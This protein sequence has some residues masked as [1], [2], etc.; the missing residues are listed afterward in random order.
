MAPSV[1][2]LGIQHVD[3][4]ALYGNGKNEVLIGSVLQDPEYRKK[5]FIATKFGSVFDKD[6]K[7]HIS[8]K[9]VVVRQSC[10]AS[11]ARLQV[12]TID[13]YYQS[14][15][16]RT[17]NIEETWAEL[18]KL[19]KE[20]KIKHLGI[21]EATPEEIR[22]AH[23]I[24]PI[25]VCEIEFSLW[26]PDIRTNGILDTC[27][28]LGIAIVAYSPLGRGFLTGAYK[29]ED[30]GKDDIRAVSPRFRKEAFEENISINTSILREPAFIGQQSSTFQAL[31]A[32]S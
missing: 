32:G 31:V 27:R 29:P 2:D 23:S 25:Q 3:T 18:A 20:G 19:Q 12:D 7:L 16:D 15:V 9:P 11:L 30:F 14:R 22:K 1:L 17:I 4:A 10:E 28:E 24:A 13:L 8:G 6:G 26:T 21:C 5:C